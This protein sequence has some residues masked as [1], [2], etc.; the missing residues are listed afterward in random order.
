MKQAS[1]E[2]WDTIWAGCDYATFFHSREWAEIWSCY[3]KKNCRPDPQLIGFSDGCRVLLPFSKTKTV[4]GLVRHHTSSP[5]GT[6][7]GWISTDSIGSPHTKILQSY[8]YEKYGSLTWRINPYDP[9]LSAMDLSGALMDDTHTISLVAGF[10]D[11]DKQWSKGHASTARKARKA[12]K[13]GISIREAASKEEWQAYYAIYLDSIKRW[14][15]KVSSSYEWAFFEEIYGRGSKHIKLW[16]SEY[17]GEII[18]GALCFYAVKHVVYWHGAALEKHFN[19]RS[20]NLLMYEIIKNA[21][22]DGYAWFDF[23]PSGGHEGVMAFKKSFGALPRPCPLIS[24]T[25]RVEKIASFVRD[26]RAA[27]LR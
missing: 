4:G 6:F 13:A 2:A 24:K 7:G 22:E 17:Q 1:E 12:R 26:G 25:N 15:D 3:H 20:V 27:L 16:I 14:G 21:C 5:G 23:N 11:I 19:L 10:D 9:N 18:A 8:I